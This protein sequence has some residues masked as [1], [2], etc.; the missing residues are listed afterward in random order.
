MDQLK[1][2]LAAVQKHHFW[3]LCGLACLVGVVIA[4]VSGSKLSKEY[5]KKKSDIAGVDTQIGDVIAQTDHPNASWVQVVKDKTVGY[6]KKAYDGWV[7]LWQQQKKNI[8]VWPDLGKEF[9]GYFGLQ[10]EDAK[11]LGLARSKMEEL[12]GYYQ[13]YVT[14]TTLPKM[15]A[16]INAEW[17]GAPDQDAIG[18]VRPGRPLNPT[19]ESKEPTA[20]HPVVWASDDQQRL[21]QTYTWDELPTEVEIRCAQ[22]DMWVLKAL[23]EAI[24]RANNG[25]SV[26]TD[27]VVRT[28]QEGDCGR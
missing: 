4:Y 19:K 20:D 18:K 7:R 24:A 25:A 23:F 22:E 3:I 15:A 28:V 6:R 1:S 13:N 14:M 26:S 9:V 27:T 21:Y 11:K 17:N 12:Q 2:F 10:P 8:F 16:I 5:D